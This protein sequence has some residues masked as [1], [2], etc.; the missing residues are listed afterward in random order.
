[1]ID[2][3]FAALRTAEGQP[4]LVAKLHLYWRDANTS[5][6]AFFTNLVGVN[7]GP[8]PAELTQALVAVLRVTKVR[9]VTGER[10]YDT[11]LTLVEQAYAR[12]GH[13][14][15]ERFEAATFTA[16]IRAV[17]ERTTVDIATWGDNPDGT[18][19]RAPPR[20]PVTSGSPSAPDCSTAPRWN[21][22]VA[23][24]SSRSTRTGGDAADPRRHRARRQA[25]HPVPGGE[26]KPSPSPPAC[27]PAPRTAARTPTRTRPPSPA[28]PPRR[29]VGRGR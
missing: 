24:C 2:E 4:P 15:A 26:P 16:A 13:R 19:T 7:A 23:R 21:G 27:W 29:A 12:L 20:P 8:T 1:M 25:A 28:A 11:E 22:S 10:T 3:H 17:A 9:R 18:M 5:V 14:V 6:G